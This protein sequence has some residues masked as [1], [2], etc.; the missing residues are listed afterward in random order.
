MKIK[1][2]W[3]V[4]LAAVICLTA[5]PLSCAAAEPYSYTVLEDGTASLMCEDKSLAN[6]DIPAELDGYIVTELA[7]GC[8][9]GCSLLETV[10]IP[11]TVTSIRSYAFQGCVMLETADIPASVTLI[12]DFV[13]EGCTAL[14]EIRVDEDNTVYYD[15]DGILFK[16]GLS[17]TLMRYPAA[18][19]G[20]SYTSPENCGTVSPW[21]FTDCYYLRSVNLPQVEAIGADAFMGCSKLRKVTLS[22]SVRELIGASFAHCTSLESVTMPKRL[23]TIG[24]R[25]FF[26]CTELTGI[27]FPDKLESIGEQAFYA[28]VSMTEVTLPTSLKEIGEYAIGYSIDEDGNPAKIPDMKFE[29]AFGSDGYDYVREQGFSYHA[30][31]PQSFVFLIL[32]GIFMIIVMCIGINLELR[33]RKAEKIAEAE[34]LEEERRAKALEE[35]RK[36]KK[37]RKQK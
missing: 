26:G 1:K 11:D 29:V 22:D 34:R 9:D 10:T 30:E 12:E 16:D 36:R 17:C 20:S 35:H 14:T 25:C 33:R 13:F 27:T 19:K 5:V 7:E 23:E 18:K 32:V 2:L 8:F 24:D 21:S 15:D 31:V 3:S 6:A 37:N 4:P 28:C